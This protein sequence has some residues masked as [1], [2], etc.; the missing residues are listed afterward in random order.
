MTRFGR[1]AITTRSDS[2]RTLPSLPSL[3]IRN[4]KRDRLA[5]IPIPILRNSKRIEDV[6]LGEPDVIT[7]KKK[8]GHAK[9]RKASATHNFHFLVVQMLRQSRSEPA[10]PLSLRKPVYPNQRRIAQGSYVRV[11]SRKFV[12]LQAI[13]HKPIWRKETTL[14]CIR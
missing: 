12:P 3:A 7:V 4:H 5:A 6:S 2:A 10:F 1:C 11:V 8:K 14:S 13:L 9:H